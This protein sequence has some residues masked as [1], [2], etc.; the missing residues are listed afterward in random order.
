MTNTYLE[1]KNQRDEYEETKGETIFGLFFGFVLILAGLFNN[2]PVYGSISLNVV[3]CIVI[4]STGLLLM[5]MAVAVPSVLKY[6]YKGFVFLGKL[7]GRAVFLVLLTLI[8]IVLVLP[9]GL[10]IRRKRK[11]FGFQNWNNKYVGKDT[12]FENINTTGIEGVDEIS[13][14]SFLRNIYNLF[15][16]FIRNRR[17]PLIPVAIILILL[18]LILFFISSSVVF[19]FFIYTLF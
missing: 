8:Y 15:S 16:L 2:L 19:N 6:P 7:I 10:F 17:L 14:R 3:I 5:L 11:D 12:A 9:V 1:I 13:K 4:L 18:G